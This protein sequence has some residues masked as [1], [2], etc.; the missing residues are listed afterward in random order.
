MYNYNVMYD[1]K[2]KELEKEVNKFDI[3]IFYTLRGNAQRLQK[4]L[5]E[6][7]KNKKEEKLDEKEKSPKQK[8]GSIHNFYKQ[9]TQSKKTDNNANPDETIK[10][11]HPSE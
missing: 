2:M 8:G 7:E 11:F 6:E 9:P 10:K 1:D 4:G 5:N 3:S